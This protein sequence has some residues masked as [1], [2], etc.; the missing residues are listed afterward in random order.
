MNTIGQ[1]SEINF[2]I[3]EIF[4]SE[5]TLSLRLN[6]FLVKKILGKKNVGSKKILGQKNFQSKNFWVKKK[7][8]SKNFV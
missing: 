5:W 6:K 2:D 3:G 8:K 1:I 4:I 7:F